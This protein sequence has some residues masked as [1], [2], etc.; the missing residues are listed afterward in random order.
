MTTIVMTNSVNKTDGAIKKKVWAFMEK[1]AQSDAM[2]GLHIEPMNKPLDSRVRTGRVDD[3]YR[4]VLFRLEGGAADPTYVYVGTWPH[5][6][7]IEI[8]RSSS[9]RINPYNGVAELI[10]AGEPELDDEPTPGFSKPVEPAAKSVRPLFESM[11]VTLSD[12]TVKLGLDSALASRAMAAIDEDQLFGVAEHAPVWQGIALIDL[13]AGT[14]VDAVLAALQVEPAVAPVRDDD[15]ALIEAMKHPAAQMT[16]SF[17]HDNEELRRAIEDDDFSAWKVFLHPEQRR[18]VDR[19]YNGP[20]R[21]SGG[22]G[23]GKTVVLLH[24]ARRLALANP[25]A[26]VVLTTF[27]V[28][29]AEN[30]R[31]DLRRLD[32]EVAI[33]ASLGEPGVF[34]SG[35]DALSF[36]VL[37]ENTAAVPAATAAVLGES[38]AIKGPAT[39]SDRWSSARAASG[40]SE[41]ANDYLSPM[42]L[43]AEYEAIIVPNRIT[44]RDD[45]FTARRPGRGVA[46]DR[47]KRDLVWKVVAAYRALFGMQQSADFSEVAAVAAQIYEGAAVARPAD[48]VLVD[49]GQDLA[50]AKWRLLR[51]LAEPGV[52]DL[53]IAEDSHQRIYGQR[54]TLSRWGIK[55]VGRSQR[56][57]LNYRTTAQNLGYAVAVLEAGRYEDLESEKESTAGYR[58]SRRGPV[59]LRQGFATLSEELDAVSATLKAWSAEDTNG[60]LAVLVRTNGFA[61]TVARG[62]AE[63]DVSAVKVDKGEP[64]VGHVAVMSMHRAKGTEFSRVCIMGAGAENIP[65][66]TT[67]KSAAAHGDEADA[68]LRER[69]L[70]Y[71]AATRARDA[72]MITWT[73]DP[74]PLLSE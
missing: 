24:R 9:L 4:A 67:M 13:A 38:R 28:N 48:H 74:S 2:P 26:R 6:E 27:T 50:P 3:F 71:V 39:S 18:Y 55:I 40:V 47:V 49:E 54:T 11:G 43:E 30:L 12:L 46:L 58:S 29:L 10:A 69:S 36:A 35:V 32:P 41:G 66:P 61:D 59:P 62:L 68:L 57:T 60:S 56:L 52:N 45:Y 72:L 14:S 64:P 44:T 21:L 8:A 7:A 23:T 65:N 53:F 63:R 37:R 42:F 51:A 25:S 15:E 19:D 33:A 73:G 70:F 34:I 5:D 17:V 20:F 1:L 16:F 31:R 22:A